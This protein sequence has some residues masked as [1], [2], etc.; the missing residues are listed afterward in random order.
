M[1]RVGVR[2]THPIE[3]KCEVTFQAD[4]KALITLLKELQV[5][6]N[7]GYATEVS[8]VDIFVALAQLDKESNKVRKW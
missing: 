4:S 8:A 6:Q 2:R 7:W 3:D 5:A 1:I